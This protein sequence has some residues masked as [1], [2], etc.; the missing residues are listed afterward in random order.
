M[1]RYVSLFFLLVR[2]Q[3]DDGQ[4]AD[5]RDT[6]AWDGKYKHD[7]QYYECKIVAEPQYQK[8]G[9]SWY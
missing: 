5:V 6:Q 2:D 3:V 8:W 9:F 7:K 1:L 4:N